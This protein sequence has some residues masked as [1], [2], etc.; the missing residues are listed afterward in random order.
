MVGTIIL[1]K[2]SNSDRLQ[3]IPS[4]PWDLELLFVRAVWIGLVAVFIFLGVTGRLDQSK[5]SLLLDH[6][7]QFFQGSKV[8][9]GY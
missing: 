7:A 4:R 6:S 5:K 1:K 8:N 9:H 3:K 2:L